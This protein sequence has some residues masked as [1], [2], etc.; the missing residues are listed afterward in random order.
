MRVEKIAGVR[1]LG[2]VFTK[3]RIIKVFFAKIPARFARFF[4][5]AEVNL[6]RISIS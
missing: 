2:G 5:S 3:S 1:W 4:A 6:V